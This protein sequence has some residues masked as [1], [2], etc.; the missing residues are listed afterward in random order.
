MEPGGHGQEIRPP[1]ESIVIEGPAFL[2]EGANFYNQPPFKKIVEDATKELNAQDLNVFSIL[3]SLGQRFTD[4]TGA[5]GEAAHTFKIR[6]NKFIKAKIA[7]SVSSEQQPDTKVAVD[8]VL[9][10]LEVFPDWIEYLQQ[11]FDKGRY[12]FNGKPLEEGRMTSKNTTRIPSYGQWFT[13]RQ[14]RGGRVQSAALG[15]IIADAPS[16]LPR[17]WEIRKNRVTQRF[18]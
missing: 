18:G 9:Q 11:K 10:E 15:E 3:T 16:S 13:Q 5:D 2:E 17:K 14:I 8:K 12:D 7:R 6:R 4:P 1:S